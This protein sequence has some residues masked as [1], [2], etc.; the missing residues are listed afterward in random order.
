MG[1]PSAPRSPAQGADTVVWLANLPA[2]GPTGGF[3]GDRQPIPW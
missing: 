2:D 3:F 1:G